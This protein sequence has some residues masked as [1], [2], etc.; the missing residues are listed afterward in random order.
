MKERT[1]NLLLVLSSLLFCF[2]MLGLAEIIVRATSDARFLGVSKNLFVKD[3]FKDSIGNN[4][5]VTAT[6]FGEEAHI[7]ADGFRVPRHAL[8]KDASLATDSVLVLGDSVAFGPGV[9]EERTFVGVLRQSFPDRRFVN[10]A[11]MGYALQDYENVFATLLERGNRFSRVLLFFCLN[12]VSPASSEAIRQY[13]GTFVPAMRSVPVI[14][15]I[16][17]FVR[18]RSK[19]YVVLK[20]WLTDPRKRYFLADEANY[21][22]AAYVEAQFQPLVRMARLAQERGMPLTVVIVPYAYQMRPEGQARLMPQNVVAKVLREH[23]VDFVDA[24]R[25]FLDASLP[26]RDLYLPYDQTHL[27]V[28]GHRVMG[29]F[30]ANLLRR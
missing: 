13:L 16:N 23:R 4:P 22:D 7:D 2:L 1:Q 21:S 29:D 19:L 6:A 12:D 27:S 14:E 11:V 3:R 9:P 10:T 5:G 30:L 28:E 8:E 15:E 18:E 26:T 17:A 24:F 20:G 25:L